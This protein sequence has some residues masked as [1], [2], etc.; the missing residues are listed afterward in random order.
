M[1]R[2]MTARCGVALAG[3]VVLLLAGCDAEPARSTATPSSASVTATG[4]TAAP[5]VPETPGPAAPGPAAPGTAAPSAP[6]SN[7]GPAAPGTAVT[8]S[9][10]SAP[11]AD[12]FWDPCTLPES[13]L[14]AAGLD[15]ATKQ[16]L[17]DSA[18]PT[19]QMCKWQ[20]GDRAFELVMAAS[21]RTIDTMLEPGAYTDLR[22]TEYQGRKVIQ[23]RYVADV[24]KLV[25]NIATPAPYG[26]IAFAVRNTRVQT[27]FGDPCTD[28]APVTTVLFKS[29][30]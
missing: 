14:T 5:S 6:D 24:H 21:D 9:P 26:S 29:L 19:W 8:A 2:T 27:D 7:P 16:R 13:A 10:S 20:A 1:F 15:V 17:T 18:F 12:A 3:G 30:P 28:A 11:A 22:R 23:F 25:C 4:A